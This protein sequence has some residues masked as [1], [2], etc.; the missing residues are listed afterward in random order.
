MTEIYIHPG[1]AQDLAAL[2]PDC[3]AMIADP[4]Y[5][6]HVHTHAT[7]AGSEAAP[8]RLRD[9]GFT[10]L[11]PDYRGWLA[12]QAQRVMRWSLVYS[13]VESLWLWRMAVEAR[14][15]DYLRVLPWIRWSQPQKSGDRPTTY[16]EA[17]SVFHRSTRPRRKHWN[18]RGSLPEIQDEIHTLEEKALRGSEKHPT[19]KPLDQALRLVSAFSDPGEAV[20]DPGCGEG[21]VP[22]ACLLLGRGCLAA[23]TSEQWHA[24]AMTRV[25]G[26]RLGVLADRDQERIMRWVESTTA[27][28]KSVPVPRKKFEEKTHERAQRRLADVARVISFLDAPRAP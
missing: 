1:R 28:A 5:R 21:T 22:L 17:V 14:G 11:T 25:D 6:E 12:A 15:G 18:G 20:F 8:T 9:F 16:W 10:H 19:A 27:E 13:D 3:A 7:S 4:P 23:E 2:V 26:A 24:A